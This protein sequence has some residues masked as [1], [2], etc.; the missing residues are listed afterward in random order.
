MDSILFYVG[1][2]YNDLN[3][4]L[5]FPWVLSN[6]TSDTIDLSEPSNYRDLSKVSFS[7]Y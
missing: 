4:Y 2:S 5:I 1:R 3:Q 6:F 7:I